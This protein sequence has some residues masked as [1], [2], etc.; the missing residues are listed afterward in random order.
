M[1]KPKEPD[2]YEVGYGKPPKGG[3]FK[4]GVSGNPSG[5]P[6]KP[7]DFGS[8]LLQELNS[9]VTFNENGQQKVMK[10][11]KLVTRQFVNKAASGNL[12]AARFV[13]K[14][15]LQA[16]ATAAEQHQR[17]QNNQKT[18]AEDLSDEEL[19]LFIRA[20]LKKPIPGN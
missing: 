19:A 11:S 2:D 20:S 1:S 12:P 13:F 15:G 10:K 3:Q 4:K 6:K 5:R 16:Q 17:S 18:K 14:W 8:E 7:S 9:L